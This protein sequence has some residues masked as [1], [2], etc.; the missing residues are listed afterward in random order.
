MRKYTKQLKTLLAVAKNEKDVENAYRETFNKFYPGSCAQTLDKEDGFVSTP[1]ISALFEA[2]FDKKLSDKL[3]R[4]DVLVQCL[5]YL[6]NRATK[7]K[8]M[9]SAIF[10]GDKDECGAISRKKLDKYLDFPGIDWTIAASTAAKASPTLVTALAADPELFMHVY[11]IDEKF[12]FEDAIT[13][14]KSL[15]L[16]TPHSV[17]V[18]KQNIQHIFEVFSDNV[19]KDKSIDLAT[20]VDIFMKGLVANRDTYLHPNKTNVLVVGTTEYKVNEDDYRAFI[21]HHQQVYSPTEIME[22]TSAR[23]RLLEDEARRRAG[24]FYTPTLWVNKAHDLLTAT[25]DANW[26]DEYTVW[27]CCC[28]TGNLTRDYA[29]KNLLLSDIDESALEVIRKAGYN[30]N[31][32]IFKYD[33]LNDVTWPNEIKDKKVLFL[34]N[35][36]YG[37][38][39]SGGAKAKAGVSDTQVAD[40]MKNSGLGQAS[41]ELYIQFIYR[42]LVQR[43]LFSKNWSLATFAPTNFFT[44]S[45]ATP[46]KNQFLKQFKYKDGFMFPSGVFSDTSNNFGVS[47]TI[48]TP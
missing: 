8:V 16:D 40:T 28:G 46:F 47:F 26:K 5:F 7:G 4:A 14:L 11:S 13:K 15:E 6:K 48:W 17:K 29:F 37:T 38:S 18:N 42:I 45:R 12:T 41:Q 10:I 34:I 1:E 22:I 31:A 30:K 33:F 32:K 19:V 24:S 39:K 25:L 3:Q 43:E 21:E 9:P 44:G 23:D 35:P 36:P 2:K 27:D 20:K